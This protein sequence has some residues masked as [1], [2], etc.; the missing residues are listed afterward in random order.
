MPKKDKE[1]CVV[2]KDRMK[3]FKYMQEEKPEIV[4]ETVKAEENERKSEEIEEKMLSLYK[5]GY[6]LGKKLKKVKKS[7]GVFNVLKDMPEEFNIVHGSG[8]WRTDVM[9]TGGLVYLFPTL[10]MHYLGIDDDLIL[11]KKLI[12]CFKNLSLASGYMN[13]P[14]DLENCLK[15]VENLS[16]LTASPYVT[17]I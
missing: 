12:P 17:C 15:N 9:K 1:F 2:A 3:L 14:K 5:D 6:E 16:L 13:F 10:Q 4:S 7:D 8:G 11:L